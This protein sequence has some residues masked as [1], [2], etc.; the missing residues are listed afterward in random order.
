MTLSLQHQHSADLQVPGEA[1]PWRADRW[2][3]CF[4]IT[5]S[6]IAYD[7]EDAVASLRGSLVANVCTALGAEARFTLREGAS[8]CLEMAVDP[9][10]GQSGVE[11]LLALKKECLEAAVSMDFS[12]A[13]QIEQ[14]LDEAHA[15]ED[16]DPEVL[17]LLQLL[18]AKVSSDAD[19][20]VLLSI[21][22][23]QG[24]GTFEPDDEAW[25][26]AVGP[27]FL[28]GHVS[29]SVALAPLSEGDDALPMLQ[30]GLELGCARVIGPAFRIGCDPTAQTLLL[31]TDLAPHQVDV[32]EIKEAIGGLL[33]LAQRLEPRLF[34]K[35]DETSSG[36]VMSL[37]PTLED[38]LSSY[39]ILRA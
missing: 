28:S 1:A 12:Q 23:V 18:E 31:C 30:R 4:V 32:T 21:D 20:A 2:G 5:T 10:D 15:A 26:I 33:L 11:R 36:A 7:V 25:I 19:M 13:L 16:A 17:A 29:L 24:A 37:Q 14:A 34:L 6:A 38:S 27:S 8:L 3:D 22:E 39:N 35:T 9:E